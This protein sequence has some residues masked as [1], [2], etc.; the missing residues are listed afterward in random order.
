M[1]HQLHRVPDGT[2]RLMVQ[3]IERIRLVDL[4]GTEPVSG[5][6]GRGS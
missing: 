6:A 5:R 2:V 3:G 1:I 4:T